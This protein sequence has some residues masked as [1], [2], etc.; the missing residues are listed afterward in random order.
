MGGNVMEGGRT[1]ESEKVAE[2]VLNPELLSISSI[3]L[4]EPLTISKAPH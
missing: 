1:V 4:W 3:K 2:T